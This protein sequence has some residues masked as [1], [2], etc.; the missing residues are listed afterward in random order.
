MTVDFAGVPGNITAI[1]FIGTRVC[2]VRRAPPWRGLRLTM[3]ERSRFRQ[4]LGSTWVKTGSANSSRLLWRVIKQGWTSRP[5]ARSH[6]GVEVLAV[7]VQAWH[8]G[9]LVA[10]LHVSVRTSRGHHLLQRKVDLHQQVAG[11]G[12]VGDPVGLGK[13]VRIF[14]GRQGLVDEPL[15]GFDVPLAVVAG[16]PPLDAGVP[17]RDSR[18]FALVAFLVPGQSL[19]GALGALRLGPRVVLPARLRAGLAPPLGRGERWGV[20]S[21]FSWPKVSALPSRAA[22]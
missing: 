17:L 16:T 7:L 12:L 10:G 3:S 22:S 20:N 18:R 1:V 2:P 21:C 9:E 13:A 4:A 14:R 15:D 11:I 8:R 5:V 19:I 6:G